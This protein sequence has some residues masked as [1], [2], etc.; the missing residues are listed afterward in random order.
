MDRGIAA[1]F[2]KRFPVMHRQFSDL[3]KERIVSPGN[4]VLCRLCSPMVLTLAARQ[5]EEDPYRREIIEACLNRFAK[6]YHALNITSIAFPLIRPSSKFVSDKAAL[7]MM[8]R[9]LEGLPIHIEVYTNVIEPAPAQAES[10]AQ[11]PAE[12]RLFL[13]A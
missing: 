1:K 8:R 12:G 9:H 2:R 7:K 5:R 10:A 13:A 6:N 11:P 4:S 3:C